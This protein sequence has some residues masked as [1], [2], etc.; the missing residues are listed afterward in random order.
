MKELRKF[1]E[2]IDVPASIA[3]Y[4]PTN[5]VRVGNTLLTAR[6]DDL[7]AE[8]GAEVKRFMSGVAAEN[9]LG[10]TFIDIEEFFKSGAALSC[11][12]MHFNRRSY[13]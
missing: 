9:G 13:E 3:P 4:G 1:T 5:S 2:I 11:L 10:I 7:S 12:V 8:L 6:R